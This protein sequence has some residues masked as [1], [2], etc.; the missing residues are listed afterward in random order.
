MGLFERLP[1]WLDRF[2]VPRTGLIVVGAH[3]GQELEHY[4]RAGFSRQVW[5]EPQAG[6]FAALKG[7]LEAAG[8][9]GAKAF[10]V[11]CGE[12]DGVATMYTIENN[13][14]LSN[15]LL[16]PKLHL[17][18]YPEMPAGRP[19]EVPVVRLDGLLARE[20]LSVTDYSFLVMDVQGF[21]LSVLKGSPE[22]LSRGVRA[23]LTEVS[24]AELYEGCAMLPDMDGFLAR[25]GFARV[26][27][28]LNRHR[29]G[30]ALYVRAAGLSAWQRARLAVFG[31]GRR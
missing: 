18:E 4:V 21:E 12:A 25:A 22:V 31:P 1:G 10:N 23:I 8:A 26:I 16:K 30:D 29:Y 27:T 11:A 13:Q 14:G 6:P 24:T 3:E 15:S 17:S 20:G 7:R 5:V 19:I 28:R 9:K 2:A